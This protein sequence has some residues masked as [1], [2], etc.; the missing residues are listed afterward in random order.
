[1]FTVQIDKWDVAHFWSQSH[2]FPILAFEGQFAY[3][4]SE[5][6]LYATGYGPGNFLRHEK[7]GTAWYSQEWKFSGKKK[8]LGSNARMT[9]ISQQLWNFPNNT[10]KKI[11]QLT[12]LSV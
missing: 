9:S 1:M 4:D 5:T 6:H 8:N 12:F 10:N 2:I 7:P 11:K 3:W